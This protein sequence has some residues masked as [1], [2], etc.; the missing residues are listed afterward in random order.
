[1]KNQTGQSFAAAGNTFRYSLYHG[2]LE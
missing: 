2:Q 1:L